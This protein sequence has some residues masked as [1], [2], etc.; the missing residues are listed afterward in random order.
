MQAARGTSLS[1]S[2]NPSPLPTARRR[3]GVLVAVAAVVV[4]TDLASKVAVVANLEGRGPVELAGG[5]LTLRVIRNPGAAFGL[6]VGMTVLFTAVAVAVVIA[7]ARIAPRLRSLPWA[8]A[9]GLILGGAVGNL[10]DRLFRSPGPFRGHVV[11]FFDLAGFPWIFNVADA[12]ITVG[13]AL[14]VLTALR[15]IDYDGTRAGDQAE[16]AGP[17]EDPRRG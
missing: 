3:L 13:G 7:I 15:G 16:P 10:V 17:P 2:R 8:L 12:G 1:D 5:L 6:G 14:M 4:A 9:L 11:D